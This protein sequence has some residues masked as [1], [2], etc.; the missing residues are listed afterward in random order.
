MKVVFP[1][2][3]ALVLLKQ[4]LE[5]LQAFYNTS[6]LTSK[7]A[8]YYKS[9]NSMIQ[10]GNFNYIPQKNALVLYKANLLTIEKMRKILGIYQE[11]KKNTVLENSSA[12]ESAPINS[13]STPISDNDLLSN[14]FFQ[15]LKPL[16]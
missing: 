6:L 9:S 8:D 7:M 1:C 14:P 10:I 5:T 16:N 4:D 15:T 12:E 2:K 3:G 11:T 13:N